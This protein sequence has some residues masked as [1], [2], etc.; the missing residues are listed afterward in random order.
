MIQPQFMPQFKNN[1]HFHLHSNFLESFYKLFVM[2]HFLVI[3]YS[4]TTPC[5]GWCYR[6]TVVCAVLL[7]A[8]PSL[9]LVQPV[10]CHRSVTA[11]EVVAGARR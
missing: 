11:C 6:L 9:W 7:L 1:L 2:I 4:G 8:Q 5:C 3:Y 10:L